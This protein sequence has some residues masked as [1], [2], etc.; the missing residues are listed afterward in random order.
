MCVSL[1]CSTYRGIL[2]TLV[3]ISLW[4]MRHSNAVLALAVVSGV[5]GEHHMKR[6]VLPRQGSGSSTPL[7]IT[8]SC[9]ETIYPG[10]VTQSGT[11]PQSAGFELSP[12]SNK[13][14][15]VSENWQGRVW[16]RTNCTF[17]SQ[18]T[19]KGGGKA[20][21]TGDCNGA[22]ECKVTVR[23]ILHAYLGRALISLFRAKYQSHWP[24][25]LSMLEMARPTL[26]SRLLMDTMSQWQSYSC[27]TATFH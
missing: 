3:F 15:S 9:S 16:G 20:C 7:V 19:S 21:G 23:F 10:I 13:T 26:T 8:N 2:F 18:G 6:K 25:S 24:S 14:Q 4:K 11:G 5:R 17:N 12:G 22:V 1:Q 27:H